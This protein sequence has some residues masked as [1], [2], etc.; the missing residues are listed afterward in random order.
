MKT[1]IFSNTHLAQKDPKKGFINLGCLNL[2]LGQY[3]IVEDNNLKF[4][5]SD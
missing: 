1:L 4:Y 2:G 5:D 3:L